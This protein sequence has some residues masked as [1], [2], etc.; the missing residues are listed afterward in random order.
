LMENQREIEKLEVDIKRVQHYYKN[1]K[2]LEVVIE[3]DI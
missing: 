1:L 2:H 3:D